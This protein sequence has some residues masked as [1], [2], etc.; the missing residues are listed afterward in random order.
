[1]KTTDLLNLK[2]IAANDSFVWGL[3]EAVASAIEYIE[4]LEKDNAVLREEL[5]KSRTTEPNPR[6]CGFTKKPVAAIYTSTPSHF[7]LFDDFADAERYRNA[8]SSA[9]LFI[10]LK[11][12]ELTWHFIV[13]RVESEINKETQS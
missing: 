6:L 1:M 7:H 10:N 3:R 8:N 11:D 4:R 9:S 2:S 5:K 12:A 13:L